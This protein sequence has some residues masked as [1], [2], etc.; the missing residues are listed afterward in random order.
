MVRRKHPVSPNQL[1][2]WTPA[3]LVVLGTIWGPHVTRDH[4]QRDH[5]DTS[6]STCVPRLTCANG[7]I[8]GL[9][10]KGSQVQILSARPARV[11]YPG[12]WPF[13]FAP[14]RTSGKIDRR[15]PNIRSDLVVEKVGTDACVL[16]SVAAA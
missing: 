2:F 12:R 11:I 14:N 1:A 9:G 4:E 7:N 15:F 5:G 3:E 8:A 6:R 13:F 16:R 10:V